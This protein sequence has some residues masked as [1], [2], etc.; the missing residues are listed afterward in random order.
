[1]ENSKEFTNLQVNFL[2]DSMDLNVVDLQNNILSKG[3]IPL[4]QLFDRNKGKNPKQQ[5]D[6][7]LEF[8]IGTEL[9]P[10]MVKIGE[11]TTEEERNEILYLIREFKDTFAWTY[12][13]LRAY[14]GDV[15]QHVISLAEGAKPF[16]QKI[17]HINH[18]LVNQ[19]QKEL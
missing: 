5:I 17:R 16:R 19:I 9:D 4:E 2:V 18:K 12:D 11:G 1:M 15:I 14:R 7:V 13:D 10:R 3:C 6:K 8:N